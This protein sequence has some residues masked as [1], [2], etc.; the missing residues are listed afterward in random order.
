MAK[1]NAMTR[2]IVTLGH[3]ARA[4]WRSLVLWGLAFAVLAQVLMLVALMVRF[5]ALPNYVT[6]YDWIETLSGSSNP[7]HRGPTFRPSVPKNG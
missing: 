5:Q 1:E 3:E 4:S 7:P 2:T 6:F